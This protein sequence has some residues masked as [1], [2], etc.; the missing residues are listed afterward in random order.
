MATPAM[1]SCRTRLS[2]GHTLASYGV[3][4]EGH[5]HDRRLPCLVPH[6]GLDEDLRA[7]AVEAR[8]EIRVALLDESAPHLARAGELLV[9]RVE[10]LVQ[11]DE[12]D[13]LGR[14]R[15]LAVDTVDMVGDE[16][17]HLGLLGEIGVRRVGDL[18][19]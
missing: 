4:A 5:T 10:L 3:D 14:A 15:E 2:S 17:V 13:D 12:P 18:P 9:V 1:R 6:L 11:E 16:L 19:R 7:L 8:D